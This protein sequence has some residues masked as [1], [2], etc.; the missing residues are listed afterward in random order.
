MYQPAYVTG[1]EYDKINIKPMMDINNPVWSAW[2][3]T[4][5]N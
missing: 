2:P 3:D 5:P 4:M 1:Q